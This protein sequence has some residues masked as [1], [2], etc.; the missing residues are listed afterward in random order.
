MYTVSDAER[1]ECGRPF[2]HEVK[3][4]NTLVSFRHNPCELC[5]FRVFCNCS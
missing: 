1:A 5:R 3:R 2:T 4:R